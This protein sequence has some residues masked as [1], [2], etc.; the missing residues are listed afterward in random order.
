MKNRPK[1]LM[2]SRHPMVVGNKKIE[3]KFLK[4]LKR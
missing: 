1:K 4:D 2:P 3:K